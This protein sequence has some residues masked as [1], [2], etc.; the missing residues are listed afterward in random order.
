MFCFLL[1]CSISLC[2][3]SRITGNS[4]GYV[5]ISGCTF[6]K[7]GTSQTGSVVF[8]QVSIAI[9]F[10]VERSIFSSCYG[11]SGAGVIY[12][13]CLNGIS[14]LNFVCSLN[15]SIISGT[16]HNSAAF[17]FIS[18]STTGKNNVNYLSI[19][20]SRGLISPF[21]ILKGT[22]SHQG[23]N[24]SFNY[25]GYYSGVG[26]QLSAQCQF[27][28][29]T[30]SSTYATL[31]TSI[32]FYNKLSISSSYVNFCNNSQTA[33]SSWGLIAN[34]ITSTTSIYSWVFY[35]NDRLSK[36]FAQEDGTCIVRSCK[37]DYNHQNSNIIITTPSTF[38]QT[39][40]LE[41]LGDSLC[42]RNEYTYIISNRNKSTWAVF[43]IHC[44]F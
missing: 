35:N 29:S 24:S 27:K 15:S 21:E 11:S 44:I 38:D 4:N 3:S 2:P 37:L 9:E 18:S 39:Y 25:M 42:Y 5:N 8:L 10:V 19:S 30:V 26:L 40:N 14:S 32:C 6:E 41:L 34:Y 22:Q 20:E 7:M 16:I 43:L 12:F 23:V 17:A 31:H 1:I 33:K 13:N 28:F 36:L